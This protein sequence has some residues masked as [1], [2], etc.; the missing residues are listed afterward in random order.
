MEDPSQ[1]IKQLKRQLEESE[2]IYR[3]LVESLPLCVIR[4]DARGRFEFANEL[5]CQ[6]MGVSAEEIVGQ[7]DFD[8]FPA[9]LAKK[10]LADDREV[11]SGGGLRHSVE[12]HQ[13]PSGTSK[14]VE[15]W[16]TPQ[17][18]A[19]GEAV[20]VQVLFWDITD[21]KDTEHQIEFERFLLS[22]LLETVPD[23]VYFK[24]IDSRF[25]RLSRSCANKLGLADPREAI[26]KSDA[27]FF[28]STHAKASLADER[29]IIET[30]EMIQSKIE[31]ESYPD[32]EDTW[33]STTKGPLR[34]ADGQIVGTYGISRDV[35]KQ[36]KAENELSHERDLLKTIINN[37]PDLIYVKD[38]AGRFVLANHAVLRLL[39]MKNQEEISG[40]TD[41]D[42]SPPEIA[43]TCVADD[44]QVIRTGEPLLD[45][46]ESRPDANG[47]TIWLL[48]TKVPLRN[49]EGD[50]IGLV[51]VGRDITAQKKFEQDVLAAKE[52]A[53]RAN[54]AKS[55]FLANMSHEIRTP[56]NAIIGMTDLVLDTQ[57]D[58]NQR[59]FLSMVQESGENLLSVINDILDFSKIE[60][61]KFEL[62][63]Q[64]FD[65][66]ECIGDTMKTLGL[67]AHSKGLELAFR[68]APVVPRFVLGDVGRLRQVL[69]NLVGNAIKFTDDGEVF[70]QV[71]LQ[72]QTDD[73]LELCV[74]VRDTGIGIPPER[75]EAIF[76]E[77]E[78][79]DTSVTRKFGGTGLGLAIS[80]RLVQL[81]GGTLSVESAEGVGSTFRFD[82]VMSLAD[83]ESENHANRGIVYVGGTKVLVVDDN[84]TN[85]TILQEMLNN[86]GM[87]PVQAASA[88]EAIGLLKDAQSGD[89]PFK[90]VI[91]DVHMPEVSGYELIKQLRSQESTAGIPI[92]VLTS[93]RR[94]DLESA[95]LLAISERLLKPIKQSELFD[96]IVRT[97]GVNSVEEAGAHEPSPTD[98]RLRGLRV[99][100]AEDNSI[101]QKLAVG[102]LERFGCLTTVVDNGEQ[103]VEHADPERFD[104]VLMDIQMPIKDGLAATREIRATESAHLPIIAMTA[105]AMKGDREK[106]LEAG[107]DGYLAKPIRITALQEILASIHRD[108]P[109][110][111][112]QDSVSQAPP[113]NEHAE[114]YS[115][116]ALQELTGNNTAL[117]NELLAMYLQESETLL[118]GIDQAIEQG[119]GGEIR[120]LTHT[121]S[122]ASRSIAAT[123][124]SDLAERV[125]QATQTTDVQSISEARGQLT[126]AVTQVHDVIGM[127]LNIEPRKDS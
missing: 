121:L 61:G 71:E 43:C 79:V 46:E 57:L 68:V 62:D 58:S 35:S 95:Q 76:R 21:Q 77:F 24:D 18:N 29:S 70:V 118:A 82:V 45:R 42:F 17:L 97:L 126:A 112:P 120:R 25:I 89:E 51:G 8:L 15:V 64:T 93:G 127:H 114:R 6:A 100:L 73:E 98:E 78:Q 83:A 41:Y 20:G 86:W 85:R 34:D 7:T 104:L 105:H 99:L 80:S 4:K 75:C 108:M 50:V 122:G 59:G 63:T 5:A 117:M 111:R 49:P 30:G 16:K 107:M 109:E 113:A 12:R 27:D 38:T 101:N 90:M 3:S 2:A 28:Q 33:C 9:D 65:L 106:C 54:R 44:Q 67:K 26:G 13:S 11:M 60:A 55:D 32:R 119:D 40:K 88:P 123:R 56:M 94:D 19:A 92:I 14:H 37:V 36:I 115:L 72:R 53:D 52:A 125:R 66:R 31:R 102:V 69:I 103:A 110:K 48:T 47:E 81:M 74:S 10:Y 96:A 124:V 22:I 1:E 84:A 87:I 91:T 39:G 116:D 23:S